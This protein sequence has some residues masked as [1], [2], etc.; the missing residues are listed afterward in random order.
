[1]QCLPQDRFPEYR[2]QGVGKT[3]ILRVAGQH[4]HAVVGENTVLLD[5]NT[6]CL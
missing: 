2:T 4:I 3:D 5:E 6:V 1:L